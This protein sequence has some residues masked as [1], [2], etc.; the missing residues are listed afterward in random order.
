MKKLSKILVVM[1]VIA[2]SLTGCQKKE[3]SEKKILSFSF[4]SPAVE[5]VITESAKTIVATVPDGTSV[6]SMIPIITVSDKATVN[7]AS[8]IPMD[9]TNPVSYIVTAEDG[10]Q[11]TYI[12]TVT[13]GNGGGGGGGGNTDPTEIS[14]YIDANTTWPDL[15][16]PVDYII[17]GRVNIDGNALLTIEPG[18]TIMFT[19]TDGAI[20]VGENAGLRMVGTADKPIKF[21]GPANN[22]NKGS[23][24]QIR[25]NSKRADNVWEYVEFINGG[26]DD[27]VWNAVIDLQGAKVSMKNCTI[28]GSLGY[29]IDMEY[30]ARFTA[31][32]GNTIKNCDQY[33]IVS[34]DWVGLLDMS[35]NN[36]FSS[37][38]HNYIDALCRDINME[39][40]T[41]LKAMPIPY[42]MERGLWISGGFK[43][44]I[45]PGT[46]MYFKSEQN[47]DMEQ[48]VSLIADGTAEKPIV[49]KG[50]EDETSYWRGIKYHSTK[51]ASVM[52]YCQILNCGEDD[53]YF[54]GGCLCIYDDS[55]LTLTNCTIGKSYYYGITLDGVELFGRISHSNN[56]FVNCGHG[57]VWLEDGG[58]WNGVEYQ[59]GQILNDLP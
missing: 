25:V 33:P 13:F 4:V 46:Q 18:V 27:Y 52:N 36:S 11:A 45:E 31:F 56:T 8:G 9:F 43:L 26:S 53:A 59:S 5:A 48:Q 6:T 35:S 40:H 22:P 58:E 20:E 49:F 23:W 29:G 30:E 37:N 24:Q 39:Q 47:V 42:Y 17:D 50:M 32:E 57:N 2:A 44:T 41:T 1:L 38:G 34:E 3:S 28:D 10:T 7:P 16:L 21:V 12:V 14:G 15:G 19:G 55:R 51:E 54:H